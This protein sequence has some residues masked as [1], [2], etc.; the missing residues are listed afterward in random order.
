MAPLVRITLEPIENR[1]FMYQR[2]INLLKKH[3][4]NIDSYF[5]IRNWRNNS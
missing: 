1:E 2:L 3:R 4:R 5:Q